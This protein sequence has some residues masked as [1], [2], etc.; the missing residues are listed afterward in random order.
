MFKFVTAHFSK[1]EDIFTE[2]TK[3]AV[4]L[5]SNPMATNSETM[6]PDAQQHILDL[7][8]DN[9]RSRRESVELNCPLRNH[10]NHIMPSPYGR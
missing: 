4:N 10:G 2:K 8:R 5:R 6:D 9:A 7:G 3:L 1:A